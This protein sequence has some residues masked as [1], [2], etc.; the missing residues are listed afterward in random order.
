MIARLNCF[1]FP[2]NICKH[3]LQ[4]ISGNP[5]RVKIVFHTLELNR[6]KAV[7]AA[8]FQGAQNLINRD[9]T[10]P[11]NGRADVFLMISQKTPDANHFL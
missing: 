9:V 6:R 3:T 2:F 1:L 10:M 4:I 8:P 5:Q 7:V 11:Q